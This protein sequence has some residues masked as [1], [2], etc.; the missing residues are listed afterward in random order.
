MRVGVLQIQNNIHDFQLNQVGK[1]SFSNQKTELGN[2]EKINGTFGE[3]LDKK[4]YNDNSIS[5]SERA[6]KNFHKINGNLTADQMDRLES[7]LG[8]LKE[9]GV[10]SGVLLMDSTAF[11]LNVKNQTVMTTIGKNIVQENVFSNFDAFAV[12]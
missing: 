3:I 6:S 2:S 4:I 11:V 9:K 7:G 12:V 1:S 8:R 10:I 5:F